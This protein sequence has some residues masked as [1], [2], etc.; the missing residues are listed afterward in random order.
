MS[1][2]QL[3]IELKNSFYF[4]SALGLLEVLKTL[5]STQNSSVAQQIIHF[6]E[7]KA[8]DELKLPP[9][10]DVTN[11]PAMFNLLWRKVGA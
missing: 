3:Y 11:P 9:T 1:V 7:Q 6:Y 4:V 2:S 10:I 5:R 8:K